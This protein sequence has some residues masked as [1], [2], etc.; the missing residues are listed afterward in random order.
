MGFGRHWVCLIDRQT[1]D[2]RTLSL[3][4][5]QAVRRVEV[6]PVPVFACSPTNAWI[7]VFCRKIKL[8]IVYKDSLYGDMEIGKY[9][10]GEYSHCGSGIYHLPRICVLFCFS[11]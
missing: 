6:V 5:A 4:D 1:P 10:L 8:S 3:V 7:T 2:A 9:Q 11:R